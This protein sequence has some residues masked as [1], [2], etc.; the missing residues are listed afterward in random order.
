MYTSELIT[1]RLLGSRLTSLS[2]ITHVASQLDFFQKKE[3][4]CP[5]THEPP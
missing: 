2:R 5:P 4:G 1:K 3:A